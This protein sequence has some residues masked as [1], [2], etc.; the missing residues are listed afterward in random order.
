MSLQRLAAIAALSSLLACAPAWAAENRPLVTVEVQASGTGAA[1]SIS[2]DAVVEAVRQTTLSAQVPGA[3]VSLRVKAGDSVKAGQELLRIDARSASQNAAASD[4]QV[5]AA[6]SALNVASK[7]YERQKQLFQKQYISQSALDRAQ[8]QWQATQAQV[9]AL[10]AQAGVAR[11]QSGFFV[12][13][14]PYAGVVSEVPVTLGDMAMP[15]RALVTMHDPSELRVTAAVPQ[16]AL[17]GLGD[18]RAVRFELPG[19]ATGLLQPAR[20]QVLPVVDAATHTAQVRL[21]L[22]AGIKGVAPGAFA[23]VWLPLASDQATPKGQRLFVPA[24]AAVRR[25][26]MTGLYVVNPEGLALLRQV[27]L[28]GMKGDQVEVLS[29]I[30]PGDKVVLDPQTAAQVR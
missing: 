12:V 18:T 26:E 2:L 24:R 23:R 19:L 28:G 11:T 4:A 14:A 29:G 27:R 16:S 7:D 13:N 8:A 6:Q 5:Q 1:D 3:I 30:S 15:G 20:V 25:S 21:D 22:P 10:Q 9:R 17:A